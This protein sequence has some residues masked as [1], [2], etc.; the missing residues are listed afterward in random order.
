[1]EKH[2]S[3]Y[4]LTTDP[5][6]ANFD[7]DLQRVRK[8]LLLEKGDLVYFTHD[9]RDNITTIGKNINYL[10]PAER[11]VYGLAS[12]YFPPI[13]TDGSERRSLDEPLSLAERMFGF[14]G[15]HEDGSH[16]FKGRI[17]FEPAW[18]PTA[19][20]Y[21]AEKNWP[22][23]QTPD[24]PGVLLRL[25]PVTGPGVRAKSR[26]L[27]LEPRPS[28]RRSA[29]FDDPQPVLRGRK[30]DWHDRAPEGQAIWDKHRYSPDWHSAES[31][32]P[33]P[34]CALAPSAGN[35]FQGKISFKNLTRLELGALLYA[36]EGPNEH[37]RLK[38]GKAK[39][40][41]LGSARCSVTSISTV[42]LAARYSSL[43]L[44]AGVSS[45]SG[46]SQLCSD[47]IEEF[48]RWH[49]THGGDSDRILR[50]HEKIHHFSA[51]VSVNYFPINFSEYGWLP[52]E[53]P[54]NTK[55]EPRGQRPPAMKVAY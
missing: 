55:G 15:K 28:D 45:V 8:S 42:N 20:S 38:L 3:K 35:T 21:Q 31:Q 47:A 32:L 36:M 40:R 50:A 41:G 29:S 39:A 48:K 7:R 1:M 9:E 53:T 51:K 27:Y 18:G 49:S 6:N 10:W 54:G 37:H 23:N 44:M 24:N 11:C 30:F 19:Q 52:A 43:D 34:I 33:A 16:P 25:A 4:G 26:P 14:A 2:G 46:V 12:S 5:H 22:A 17:A 13:D